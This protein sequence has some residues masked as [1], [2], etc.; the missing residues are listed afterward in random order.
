MKR[1]VVAVVLICLALSLLAALAAADGGCLSPKSTG[2][3][4]GSG[5]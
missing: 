4:T 5:R 1:Y 2:G 3:S